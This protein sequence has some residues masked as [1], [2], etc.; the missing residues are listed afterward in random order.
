MQSYQLKQTMPKGTVDKTIQTP[1]MPEGTPRPFEAK[2][3][4]TGKVTQNWA[5]PRG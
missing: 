1:P 2:G 4:V 3:F 5:K